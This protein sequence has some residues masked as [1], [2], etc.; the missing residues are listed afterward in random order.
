MG[1]SPLHRKFA[2]LAG[3]VGKI[4]LALRCD[5]F[6]CA[7]RNHIRNVRRRKTHS[8][9]R[10]TLGVACKEFISSVAS[11]ATGEAARFRLLPVAFAGANGKGK[12]NNSRSQWKATCILVEIVEV[13]QMRVQRDLLSLVPMV[14]FPYFGW[15]QGE[16]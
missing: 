12:P 11:D 9:I 14:R 4:A 13:S 1:G 2:W 3:L 15:R 7:V 6:V 16:K 5:W 8:L 10:L